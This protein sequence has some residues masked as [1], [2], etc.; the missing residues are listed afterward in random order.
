MRK[1]LIF[2]ILITFL[3]LIYPVN[4]ANE[5]RHK[6]YSQANFSDEGIYLY[7]S[8][9]LENAVKCLDKF[10]DEDPGA[11]NFSISLEQKV[12]LTEEE[13]RFYAAK[14]IKSNVSLVVK[15]FVTLS[16]EIRKLTHSQSIFLKSI[17]VLFQ[18]ERNSQEYINMRMAADEINNSIN[19][20]EKL[21]LKNETSTLHF[22]TSDLKSRL[23]D[24]YDLVSYYESLLARFE[25]EKESLVVAVSDN[26]PFLYQEIRIYVYARNATPSTLVIDD[27]KYPIKQS[28]GSTMS[29]SFEELGEHVIYAKGL[30]NKTGEIVKS[31]LVKVY[32][33]KIPTYIFLTS[34]SAAFLNENVE[35]SGFL[36]DYYGSPLNASVAIKIDGSTSEL[37]AHMGLFRFNVTSSSEGRLNISAFYAGNETHESSQ[38]RTSIFF[39]KFPVS[40]HLEA[41]E[42]RIEIDESVNFTGRIDGVANPV[43][44]YVFINSS[45]VKRLN[46]TEE[47]NFTLNFTESGVYNVYVY[48][49]GDL[50]HKPAKSNVVEIEVKPNSIQFHWLVALIL[51]GAIIV[52]AL[53]YSTKDRAGVVYRGEEVSDVGE[54]EKIEANKAATIKDDNLET[55][56]NVENAYKTLFSAAISKYNLKKSLTPR[57]LFKTL[58]NEPFAEKLKVVT[59]LHEKAVYGIEE[60]SD[61]E[62]EVCLKLTAEILEELEESLKSKRLNEAGESK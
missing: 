37:L 19:E 14:G 49:P 9:M 10:L 53:R 61:D 44:V 46:V 12:R 62:M 40:L 18:D 26:R 57:E 56:E 22:D 29:Y 42:G 45:L 36:S 3:T 13:S 7:F 20:I 35:V 4:G 30:S 50:L 5:I 60:L 23:K 47:F 11:S 21:E 39:S 51:A 52:S 43:P 17:K 15:P 6:V 2:L 33:R 24:V 48:F 32:V 16:A 31:N 34:K 8:K 27:L 28:D 1:I 54:Q 25:F 38:A 55:L 58:E 59:Q 41:D